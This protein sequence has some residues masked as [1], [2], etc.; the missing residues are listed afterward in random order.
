MEAKLLMPGILV[1]PGFLD[2]FL[3]SFRSFE[4]LFGNVTPI[5]WIQYF[6]N[7]VS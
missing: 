3:Y 1:N 2:P 6:L 5:D 4:V 7:E